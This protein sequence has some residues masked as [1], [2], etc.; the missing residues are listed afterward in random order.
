MF[1]P[2]PPTSADA[3]AV[4]RSSPPRRTARLGPLSERPFRNLFLARALSLLGDGLVPVALAFAVL[5]VDGSA[6]SLGVVL[7]ART[8]SLVVC[9]LLGGVVADRM[10]RRRVLIASDLIRL[11]AQGASAALVLSGSATVWQLAALAALFGVGWAM[12]L[13]TSTGFVPQTVSPGRL[14]QANALIA[15]TFS[16]AQVAGPAI[17]GVLVVAVGPGWALALDA[18][19]FLASAAFVARISVDDVERAP[20]GSMWSDLRAGWREFLS[21]RWLWTSG[22]YCAVAAFFFFPAFF[23]LGPVI[24]DRALGGARSWAAIVTAFGA[25]SVAAGL[26][27]LK[28]RPRAPLLAAVVPLTLLGAP[29][30]ALAATERVAVVALAAFLGGLGLTFFNTLFETTV[31]QHVPPH[32]LS[33]V[34]SID[35]MLGQGLQPLG[36]ALVG[37]AA[38]V[39]G[40]GPPLVAAATWI[41]LTTLLVACLPSVRGLRA[42]A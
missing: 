5:R 19:T 20:A 14:Q 16:I 10:P 35:W 7:A 34:A 3:H 41:A 17:A 29:L 8:A 18:A 23:A 37:P 9:L 25:G 26:L 33:R 40:T 28:V 22:V 30:V 38:A 32:A 24:A 11:V 42:A 15:G 31:Q 13:P 39:A 1:K 21:R 36:Y 6:S 12:F 2:R 27:L 4:S